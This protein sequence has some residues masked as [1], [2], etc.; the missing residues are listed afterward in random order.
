M[1][2]S[3]AVTRL[4]RQAKE[5][6]QG[7]SPSKAVRTLGGDGRR[8]FRNR[9]Q[10]QLLGALGAA[11]AALG[12]GA[13]ALGE[14]VAGAAE[15]GGGT[16]SEFTN[17]LS[18]GVQSVTGLGEAAGEHDDPGNGG[19]S[20]EDQEMEHAEPDGDETAQVL[21]TLPPLAP[22][23]VYS[24]YREGDEVVL[25]SEPDV[26]ERDDPNLTTTDRTYRHRVF[27]DSGFDPV[28]RRQSAVNR[29]FWL[30]HRAARTG[31]KV[32]NTLIRH[33]T[34]PGETLELR[35]TPWGSWDLVLL[36]WSPEDDLMHEQSGAEE[37]DESPDNDTPAE[38]WVS[39]RAP[40]QPG[41]HELP[42]PTFRDRVYRVHESVILRHMNL[43]ARD[44]W[45]AKR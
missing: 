16:A 39:G 42:N 36:S 2:A 23:L 25:V 8:R 33:R 3:K 22:G 34:L 7:P 6:D 38:A 24:L 15:E 26:G 1:P 5:F 29:G 12:R 18:Q 11:G 32:E 10:G 9:D 28:T 27:G 19:A 30:K 20:S 41:E 45:A 13:L 21:G 44:F 37:F 4:S 35:K 43:A 40:D 17:A 31:D 14:G